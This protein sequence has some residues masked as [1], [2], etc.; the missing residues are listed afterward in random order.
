MLLEEGTEHT[1]LRLVIQEPRLNEI[2]S[3]LF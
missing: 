3:S 2:E 1:V